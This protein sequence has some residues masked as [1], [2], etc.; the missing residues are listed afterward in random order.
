MSKIK[1]VIERDKDGSGSIE[2]VTPEYSNTFKI[3]NI[4]IEVIRP[5]VEN[6]TDEN[7]YKR[8]EPGETSFTN[9]DAEIMPAYNII[10]Y[11]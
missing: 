9:I 7:G 11:G 3:S 4:Q 2:I 5:A 1:I 10:L 8:Y 6:G